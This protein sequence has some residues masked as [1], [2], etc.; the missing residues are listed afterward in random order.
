MKEDKKLECNF[1]EEWTRYESGYYS[2]DPNHSGRIFVSQKMVDKYNLDEVPIEE[3]YQEELERLGDEPDQEELDFL[4]EMK[5][6]WAQVIFVSHSGGWD[7]DSKEGWGDDDTPHGQIWSEE[8]VAW[9]NGFPLELLNEDDV[10]I[11]SWA[12]G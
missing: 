1:E 7:K 5:E 4:N 12:D 10:Y 8:F 2:H 11:Y 3:W 9:W 6:E